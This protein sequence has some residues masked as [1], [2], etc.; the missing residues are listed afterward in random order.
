MI[1][2][3]NTLK[4]IRLFSSFRNP[5]VADKLAINERRSTKYSASEILEDYQKNPNANYDK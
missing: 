4:G 5:F 1:S 2:R 3:L